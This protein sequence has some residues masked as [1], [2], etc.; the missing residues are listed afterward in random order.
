MASN[1]LCFESS[2]VLDCNSSEKRNCKS[3]P[4]DNSKMFLIKII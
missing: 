4:S 1:F 2:G 3:V